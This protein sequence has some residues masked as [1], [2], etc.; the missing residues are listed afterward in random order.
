M[1]MYYI[2]GM[3]YKADIHKYVGSPDLEQPVK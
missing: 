1:H 2:L 3:E